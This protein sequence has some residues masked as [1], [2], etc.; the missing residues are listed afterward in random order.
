M[1]NHVA[2]VFACVSWVPINISEK[3]ERR[4]SR[5]GGRNFYGNC[6]QIYEVFIHPGIE[7]H[8]CNSHM[9]EAKARGS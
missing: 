3:Q 9:W 6:K 1:T 7:V 2:R 5:L 4:V 8:T